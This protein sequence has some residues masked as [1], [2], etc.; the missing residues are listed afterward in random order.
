ML[1]SKTTKINEQLVEEVLDE[2]KEHFDYDLLGDRNLTINLFEGD[3][4]MCFYNVCEDALY[5]DV[6]L[7]EELLK[8]TI[9]H[10]LVHKFQHDTKSLAGKVLDF[11]LENFDNL[12]TLELI[13]LA[14]E[15][16]AYAVQ[17]I[18]YPYSAENFNDRT[19]LY[20]GALL[21][22]TGKSETYSIIAP[23]LVDKVQYN[24]DDFFDRVKLNF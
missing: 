23:L 11:L 17:K 21:A 2:F 24:I 22:A 13:T 18:V 16:E 12:A 10:E 19:R 15:V 1:T 7:P 20:F 9:L 4:T 14:K 3:K 6:N 8:P 5:I